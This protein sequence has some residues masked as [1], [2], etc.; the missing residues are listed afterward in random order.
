MILMYRVEHD[1][2]KKGHEGTIFQLPCD[3]GE[4]IMVAR[5]DVFSHPK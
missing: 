4:A 2:K 1:P 5:D 3:I